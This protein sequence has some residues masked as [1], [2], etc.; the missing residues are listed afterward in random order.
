MVERHGWEDQVAKV[1][2]LVCRGILAF[3]KD[4]HT[5]LL[6]LKKAA[7]SGIS[8]SEERDLGS[9]ANSL[10]LD[11]EA[12]A[13]SV[14]SYIIAS[15][16]C[17]RDLQLLRLTAKSML[18]KVKGHSMNLGIARTLETV[19]LTLVGEQNGN[20]LLGNLG[21]TDIERTLL[22][23]QQRNAFHSVLTLRMSLA[24]I[25]RKYD[26]AAVALSLMT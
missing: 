12:A 8:F 14:N 26:V 25:F 11:F 2:F 21:M 22:D 19:I 17:G 10:F 16:Q 15:L 24:I 5:I 13:M 18:G 6:P 20:D 4:L 7:E 9:P 1:H 3:N 23:A